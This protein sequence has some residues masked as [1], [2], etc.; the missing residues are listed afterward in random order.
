MHYPPTNDKF[1][2]SL[3]I[4]IFEKYNVGYVVYGHLHGKDSYGYGLQGIRNGINYK[5]VSCDYANFKLTKV[6]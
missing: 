3:F 2:S 1:E 5:L 6:M 4:E